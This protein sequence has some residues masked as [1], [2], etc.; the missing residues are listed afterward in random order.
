MAS[1]D[2]NDWHYS[3]RN[4]QV[5]D[6]L[7]IYGYEDKMGRADRLNFGGVHRVDIT[8]ASTKLTMKLVGFDTEAGKIRNSS[9]KIALIDSKG[10]EAAS[11]DF[12]SLLLH[13]NRKHNKAC[14][15]PSLSAMQPVR[16]Y[17]YGHR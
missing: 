5:R 1:S 4:I 6:F 9:G 17:S 2:Q 13:W 16:Q 3:N 15:V 11:W 7:E 14:Y 12:A 10:R 8:H